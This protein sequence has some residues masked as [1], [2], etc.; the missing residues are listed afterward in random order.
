[1]VVYWLRIKTTTKPEENSMNTI[2][3]IGIDVHQ[4]TSVIAVMNQQGKLEGE[5]ILQT[6][7][8]SII[9]FLKGQRGTLWVT[10]EEGTYA[11]WLYGV[12]QPQ[13]AKVVVCDRLLE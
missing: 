9:D 6:Q 8:A 7:P 2:K 3:Y 5:A 4:A 10:F 1:V 11:N 12:L 13:V